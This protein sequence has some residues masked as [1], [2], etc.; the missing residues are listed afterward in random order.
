[1]VLSHTD[2]FGF[3]RPEFEMSVSEIGVTVNLTVEQ[4]STK[5]IVP[6]ETAYSVFYVLSTVKH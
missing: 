3:M 1:M 5:E 4:L 6:V 2:S